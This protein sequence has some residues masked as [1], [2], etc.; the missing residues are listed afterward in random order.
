MKWLFFFNSKS[1]LERAKK[2]L[3]LKYFNREFLAFF[4]IVEFSTRRDEEKKEKTSM[5]TYES[6]TI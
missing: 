5:V 3:T 4:Y 2:E 1:E 6:K